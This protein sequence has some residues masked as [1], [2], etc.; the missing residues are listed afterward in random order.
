M[1]RLRKRRPTRHPIWCSCP[2]C[3]RAS[4]PWRDDTMLVLAAALLAVGLMLLLRTC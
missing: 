2:E 1:S 4:Q 3:M